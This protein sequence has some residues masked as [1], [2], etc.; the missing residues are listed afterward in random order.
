MDL[1][2]E[3]VRGV[4]MPHSRRYT[5]TRGMIFPADPSHIIFKYA[6]KVEA[7]YK[8]KEIWVELDNFNISIYLGV[9]KYILGL[10][11]FDMIYDYYEGDEWSGKIPLSELQEMDE[12]KHLNLEEECSFAFDV[13]P[14]DNQIIL[15]NTE[16]GIENIIIEGVSSREM[17][18]Q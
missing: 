16:I 12:F 8:G 9:D 17:F 18:R 10:N 6:L 14:G 1:K 3:K 7:I 13:T 4:M 2:Y 15:N 11:K 5:T